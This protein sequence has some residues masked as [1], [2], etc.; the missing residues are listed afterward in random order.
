MKH[1]KRILSVLLV[2]AMCLTMSGVTVFAA[3]IT[4]VPEG[5]NVEMSVDSSMSYG[6]S[7]VPAGTT[8]GY[9]AIKKDFSGA[10][11]VTFKA[12]SSN[13]NVK[14]RMQLY[15]DDTQTMPRTNL[16]ELYTNDNDYYPSNPNVSTEKTYYVFYSFPYG[17]PD[18]TFL[19]C[20]IYDW[21][22][23]TFW[24]KNPT[25]SKVTNN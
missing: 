6:H 14:V 12:R 3:E 20:W 25:R 7:W 5:E 23:P 11:K 13:Q 22:Q 1:S 19:M 21:L 16:C 9:F 10:A 17:N 2:M 24:G 15:A 18:G 8:S 4:A